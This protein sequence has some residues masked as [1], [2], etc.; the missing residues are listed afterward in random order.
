MTCQHPG[1]Y[2]NIIESPIGRVTLCDTCLAERF[3][4]KMPKRKPLIALKDYK[5]FMTSKPEAANLV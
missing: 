5:E 1:N 3:S 4:G 2:T